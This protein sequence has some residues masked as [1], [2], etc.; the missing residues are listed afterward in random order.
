MIASTVHL[1]DRILHRNEAGVLLC[2]CCAST[3]RVGQ[4]TYGEVPAVW[5]WTHKIGNV[6]NLCDYC[7]GWFCKHSADDAMQP[8]DDGWSQPVRVRHLGPK[9]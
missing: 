2:D 1:H 5:E 4:T 3:I 8:D 6:S 7:Y 9:D